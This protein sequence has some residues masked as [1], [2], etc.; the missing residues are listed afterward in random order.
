MT[1]FQSLESRRLMAANGL[2]PTFGTNGV[3][4]LG[5]RVD[6]PNG[7][8]VLALSN[9]IYVES[10]PANSVDTFGI[11]KLNADGSVDT[12]WGNNG[13]A[14]IGFDPS[15]LFYDSR[16]GNLYVVGVSY[17][18]SAVTLSVSKIDS[19]GNVSTTYDADGQFNYSLDESEDVY[20]KLKVAA[21]VVESDGQLVLGVEQRVRTD[22]K[23]DALYSTLSTQEN[24]ILMRLNTNGTYD[25]T[26]GRRGIVTVASG[27]QK[28]GGGEFSYFLN[29]D[30]VDLTD[31]IPR[32]DGTYVAVISR[33]K[34]YESGSNSGE[35]SETTGDFSVI[36]RRVGSAGTVNASRDRYFS[37]TRTRVDGHDRHFNPLLVIGRDQGDGDVGITVMGSNTVDGAKTGPVAV[38]ISAGG[39]TDVTSLPAGLTPTS[40]VRNNFNQYFLIGGS[41]VAKLNS[42]FRPDQAWGE[43]GIVTTN[44]GGTFVPDADGRLVSLSGYPAKVTRLNGVGVGTD[45]AGAVALEDNEIV[46]LGT[47]GRDAIDVRNIPKTASKPERVQVTLNGNVYAYRFRSSL[48][49]VRIDAGAGDDTIVLNG[50]KCVTNVAAGRGND[51][52][53]A[54][55]NFGGRLSFDLGAGNDTLILG[56]GESPKSILG[57][58]GVDTL[59]AIQPSALGAKEF[60][61][62]IDRS[63]RTN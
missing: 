53:N 26:F 41:K 58:E 36:L 25:R 22:D 20:S 43:N 44:V 59:N 62:V 21:G 61:T 2:D 14:A 48:T 3:A 28:S 23:N 12:T 15:H 19:D 33:D 18:T 8:A 50:L 42:S 34:G 6:T 35:F 49:T 60:E 40:A 37:I 54:G 1:H 5:T 27:S 52:V 10:S 32:S 55:D 47:S 39:A 63:A 4:Q 38:N 45:A 24:L 30:N 11:T 9:A 13:T 29:F 57:G 31:L 46:V 17:T 7:A 51:R 56:T 16:R